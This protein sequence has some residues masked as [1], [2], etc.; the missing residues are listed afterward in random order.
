VITGD[1]HLSISAPIVSQN[2]TLNLY[3]AAFAQT[4][5]SLKEAQFLE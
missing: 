1:S 5:E 2:F 4:K 3:A